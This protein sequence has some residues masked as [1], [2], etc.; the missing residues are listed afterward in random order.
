MLDNIRSACLQGKDALY[1]MLSGM[2][3]FGTKGNLGMLLET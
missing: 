1:A 2:V 3:N